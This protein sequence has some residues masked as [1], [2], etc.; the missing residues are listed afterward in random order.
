MSV[1][2]IHS[3]LN[4]STLL[5]TALAAEVHVAE[6][7]FFKFAMHSKG[8]VVSG[9]PSRLLRLRRITA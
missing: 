3:L 5:Q 1:R 2:K 9:S 4:M 8:R 7:V 6:G